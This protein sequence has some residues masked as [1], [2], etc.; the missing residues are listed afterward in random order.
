MYSGID[1]E[2]VVDSK[3]L[4]VAID[5]AKGKN[6]VYARKVQG[7]DSILGCFTHRRPEYQRVYEKIIKFKNKN[8]C[9]NVI[10]AMESTSVYGIPL[11]QFLMDK[12]LTLVL[13]NPLHVKRAKEITDNSPNKSDEKD[14]KVMA[15]LVQF[16]RF[17]SVVIPEGIEAD[18]RHLTHARE[19]AL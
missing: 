9:C 6:I 10:V 12:P 13:V 3:T 5:L 11:Q 16:R 1:R 15:D 4:I 8:E 19:R 18:L 2:V 14:P 7:P 17:L